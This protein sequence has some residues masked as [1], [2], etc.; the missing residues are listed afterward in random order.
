MA[1]GDVDD[2]LNIDASC[3]ENVQYSG[4]NPLIASEGVI[5]DFNKSAAQCARA[6]NG[7]SR[8]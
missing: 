1:Q 8:L 5:G 3:L 6:Y 7:N 2:A 4:N